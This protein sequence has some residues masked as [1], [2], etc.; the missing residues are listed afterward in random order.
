M[1]FAGKIKHNIKRLVLCNFLNLW[2]KKAKESE[3]E[4]NIRNYFLNLNQEEQDPEI[5]EIMSYFDDNPFSVFPY[6]FTK[7]HKHYKIKIFYDKICMM[8]YVLYSN[9]RM[10]FP[11]KW[12]VSRCCRYYNSVCKEQDIYSPHRYE[13]PDYV[14]KNGDIIADIGAAEGIWALTYVNIAKKIYLF[15]CNSEWITALKKTF[16][17]WKEK[18]VIVNKYISNINKDR[19]ITLDNFLNGSSINF[20]K[21]DIEGMEL[22]LLEGSTKT[23]ADAD[24]LKLLLCAYH[25]KDD[26]ENLCSFLNARGFT[27][28]Y[29]KRYM[30]F[31]Y[32]EELGEP[33]VR[34]G[35]VRAMK[36]T[37]EIPRFE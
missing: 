20:I 1:G 7:K 34:R 31:I 28:E 29:S 30:L 32:D 14:V 10:Y 22:E 6:Y 11:K 25:R 17:P 19:Y 33:Y 37:S 9:N 36:S 21:A 12:N 23:L 4:R 2:K 26:G 18:V 3:R 8:Y 27:T 16:E 24:D 35:I 5:F 15:E 13:A